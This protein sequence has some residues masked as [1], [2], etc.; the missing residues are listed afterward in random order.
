MRR[1]FQSPA[2]WRHNRSHF[3]GDRGR[4]VGRRVRQGLKSLSH[5]SSPLKWTN[6]FK[7]SRSKALLGNADPEALP[8]VY[9][10]IEIDKIL[11]SVVFLATVFQ[12]LR[13]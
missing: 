5:S 10:F 6:E 3:W 9:I 1:G 2:E 12:R 7:I 4:S 11:T 8:R 13:Q